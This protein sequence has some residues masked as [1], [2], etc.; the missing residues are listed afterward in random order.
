MPKPINYTEV[1]EALERVTA[2]DCAALR[3]L[4]AKRGARQ[5]LAAD[6]RAIAAQFRALANEVIDDINRYD[7]E[8]KPH[9]DL[10]AA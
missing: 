8:G 7:A 6:L 1:F 4:A 2:A 9:P 5:Q 10:I 3:E